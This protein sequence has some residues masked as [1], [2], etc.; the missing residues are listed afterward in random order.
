MRLRSGEDRPAGECR[1]RRGPVAVASA[2]TTG[3]DGAPRDGGAQH[4]GLARAVDDEALSAE[5]LRDV[6]NAVKATPLS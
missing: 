2:A 3:R 6:R 5:I 1:Q 4:V